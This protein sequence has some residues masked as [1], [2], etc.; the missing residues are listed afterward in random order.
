MRHSY[1]SRFEKF[2]KDHRG[3]IT[4]V[5]IILIAYRAGYRN[6]LK[7]NEFIVRRAVK[8]GFVCYGQDE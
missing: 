5:A 6:G 4:L 8:E 7:M 2:V 1:E 3:E